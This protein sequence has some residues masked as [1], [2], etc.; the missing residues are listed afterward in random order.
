MKTTMTTTTTTIASSNT[1]PTTTSTSTS[2]RHA[3]P[4][5]NMTPANASN[6]STTMNMTTHNASNM[7]NVTIVAGVLEVELYLRGN[8]SQETLQGMFTGAL[9][10]AVEI[11]LEFIV[12]LNVSESKQ[13]SGIKRRL[14]ENQT[15]QTNSHDNQTKVYDV[16]YEIMV[17]DYMDAD[18]IVEKANRIAEPGSN[19]SRL[20]RQ[21]LLETDGVVGVGKIVSKVS[22][23]KVGDRLTSVA[24]NTPSQEDDDDEIWKVLVISLS[25]AFVVVACLA[26]SA[27]LIKRKYDA[28]SGD[29][30]DGLDLVTRSRSTTVVTD[31]KVVT[32]EPRAAEAPQAVQE[33]PAS[34]PA[35]APVK[36]PEASQAVEIII[37]EAYV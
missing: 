22:A 11:P 30:E 35:P 7:T 10:A 28:K 15:N 26:Y 14:Q 13:A 19:E 18:D 12:K 24:P 32:D 1:L 23:Y 17:P 4:A 37:E 2:M 31:E 27:I 9:A 5:Q 20:F 29:I 16:A 36:E 34:T 25:T 33:T 6:K 21:T 8:V 3:L